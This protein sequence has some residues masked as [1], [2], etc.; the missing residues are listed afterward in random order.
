M[1]TIKILL[2]VT[3]LTLLTTSCTDTTEN[4]VVKP[5]DTIENSMK[6]DN[7]GYNDTGGDEDGEGGTEDKRN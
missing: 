6:F 5:I 2:F 1:K 3:V 4:L 7:A